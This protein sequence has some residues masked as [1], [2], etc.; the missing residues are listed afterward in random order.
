MAKTY[1]TRD[2]QEFVADL[3]K[4]KLKGYAQKAWEA[5]DDY[6]RS[7]YRT[8]SSLKNKVM[9]KGPK[10]NNKRGLIVNHAATAV[11]AKSKR[12]RIKRKKKSKKL[13]VRSVR[14]MI[15]RSKKI[16]PKTKINEQ[17]LNKFG[18]VTSSIN[19]VNWIGLLSQNKTSAR[20]RMDFK[21]LGYNHV[22]PGSVVEDIDVS[23][24]TGDYVGLKYEMKDSFQY[25]FKNNTNF[26]AEL[27]LYVWK[28]VDYTDN[29][30]IN[31][32][33]R[34]RDAAFSTNSMSP[35]LEDDFNQYAS[36]KRASKK[37]HNWVIHQRLATDFGGGEEAR[38]TLNVP[39]VRFD[40]N[41]Q[42]EQ[43]DTTYFPSCYYVAVRLMGKP[44]HSNEGD[45]KV[46]KVGLSNTQLD[47]RLNYVT[48]TYMEA[49]RAVR[50]LSHLAN[51]IDVPDTPIKVADPEQVGV[52]AFSN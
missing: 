4:D 36:V 6:I 27:V 41:I 5:P 28:C 45:P 7:W 37:D 42:I 44:A 8:R 30:P 32:I 25:H 17:E 19:K 40:P 51:Q 35:A 49:D 39:T 3:L 11:V 26:P 15:S 21:Q 43:G 29:D 38:L 33:R 46:I 50:T 23:A 31:E 47:Y 9:G 34:L 14:K 1:L 13:T 52:G 16:M 22:T 12:R 10:I 24:A 18:Y 20:G 2:Q 48:R